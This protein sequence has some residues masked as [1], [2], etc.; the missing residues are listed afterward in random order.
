MVP[1]NNRV[2]VDVRMVIASDDPVLAAVQR[3]FV[4]AEYARIPATSAAI[5]SFRA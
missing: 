1:D 4:T 5:E 3:P 2:P